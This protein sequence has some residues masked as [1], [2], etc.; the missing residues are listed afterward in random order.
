MQ[1]DSST[2]EAV[3][4]V[5]EQIFNLP[6]VPPL[7]HNLTVEDH[8]PLLSSPQHKGLPLLGAGTRWL[9]V[10]LSRDPWTNNSRQCAFTPGSR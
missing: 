5:V 7:A 10:R 6:C 3:Q 2:Q 8:S 1:C 9:D 4:S